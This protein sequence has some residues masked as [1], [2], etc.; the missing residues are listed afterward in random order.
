[1]NYIKIRDIDEQAPRSRI[2]KKKL[3]YLFEMWAKYPSE[4]ITS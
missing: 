3:D 2:E 1:M 4:Q